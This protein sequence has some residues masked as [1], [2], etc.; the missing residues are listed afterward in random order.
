M[1]FSKH[2]FLSF[3]RRIINHDFS[4]FLRRDGGGAAPVELLPRPTL[5]VGLG[6]SYTPPSG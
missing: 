5:A 4:E 1:V 2:H 6:R 3:I